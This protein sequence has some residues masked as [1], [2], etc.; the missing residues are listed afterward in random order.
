M[1][2][3]IVNKKNILSLTD[4]RKRIFELVDRIQES[5]SYFI[6]TEHGRPK[7]VLLSADWFESIL[8]TLELMT[9]FPHLDEEIRKAREELIA[10]K[11]VA[12]HQ[13]LQQP[14]LV[15]DKGGK[16]AVSRTVHKTRAKRSRKP[17]QGR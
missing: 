11:T 16:Y 6:L 13:I 15:A 8:E 12:L 14:A 1:R 17:K 5:G 3:Y 7:A 9:E 2:G 10:G 4:A